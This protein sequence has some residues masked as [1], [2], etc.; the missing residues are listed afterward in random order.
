MVSVNAAHGN[1]Q[2]MHILEQEAE[3]LKQTG[4]DRFAA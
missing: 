1:P 4:R 2:Q 3:A